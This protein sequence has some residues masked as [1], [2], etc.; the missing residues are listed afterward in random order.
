MYSRYNRGFFTTHLHTAD[1]NFDQGTGVVGV[2]HAQGKEGVRV[3]VQ[4]EARILLLEGIEEQLAED[5][6]RPEP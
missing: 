1:G 2:D 4:E 5:H 3:G 6:S